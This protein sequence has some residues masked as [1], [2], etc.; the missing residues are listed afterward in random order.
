MQYIDLRDRFDG[1]I[2]ALEI[3]LDIVK[4]MHP[5]F[6]FRW[7]LKDLKGTLAQ[8]LDFENE[9]RNSERCAR[10]LQHFEFLVVP[11][12]YWEQTSKVKSVV[13]TLQARFFFMEDFLILSVPSSSKE[14][15][16]RRVLRRLQNKQHRRTKETRVTF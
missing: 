13:R 10:E 6:G 15:Y 12:V 11:R 1:D 16:N 2:R 8:E 14:G 4:F 5:T 9:A 7:V 3:L